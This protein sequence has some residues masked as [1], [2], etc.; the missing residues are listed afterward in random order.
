MKCLLSKS[1]D[2]GNLQNMKVHF[3]RKVDNLV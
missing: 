3:S 1:K 2:L